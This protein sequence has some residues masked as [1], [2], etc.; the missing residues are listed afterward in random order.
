MSKKQDNFQ[1]YL[2]RCLISENVDKAAIYSHTLVG[3]GGVDDEEKVP[4]GPGR[5]GSFFEQGDNIKT[6]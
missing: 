1:D 5:Q 3:G 2:A 6:F 4:S